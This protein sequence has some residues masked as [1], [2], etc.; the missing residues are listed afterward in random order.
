MPNYIFTPG[1]TY[2]VCT[3]FYFVNF[4]TI[5]P[6]NKLEETASYNFEDRKL[7]FFELFYF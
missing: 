2:N 4:Y 5:K 7:Y 1:F 3:V 6:R